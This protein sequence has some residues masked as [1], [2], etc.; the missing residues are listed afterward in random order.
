MVI[1]CDTIHN[2]PRM[3]NVLLGAR[4]QGHA[5]LDVSALGTQV[6]AKVAPFP[7]PKLV[8]S[9][10][11]LNICTLLPSLDLRDIV[12]YRVQGAIALVRLPLYYIYREMR[13]R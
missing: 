4:S 11:C 3:H 10:A 13:E 8:I 7:S 6:S 5:P 9:G 1:A 12:A 2:F